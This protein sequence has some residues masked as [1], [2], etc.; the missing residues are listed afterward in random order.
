MSMVGG[1]SAT[2]DATAEEQN[3]LDQVK[4]HIEGQL[5]KQFT[6]FEAVSY[7]TQVVAGT[8][9]MF[10]VRIDEGY[11]HVKVGKPLPHKQE[12]PFVMGIAAEGITLE[13][14]LAPL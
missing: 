6:V 2:R 14:P 11:I 4:A 5:S 10:K 13:T 12:P 7:Q 1:F 3:V 8:N 9:Y